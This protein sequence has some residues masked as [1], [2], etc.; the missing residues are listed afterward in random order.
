[1]GA[2]CWEHS[3]A[4]G[5]LGGERPGR[6]PG[7]PGAGVPRRP[8]APAAGANPGPRQSLLHQGLAAL[9]HGHPGGGHPHH[10]PAFIESHE[11]GLLGEQHAGGRQLQPGQNLLPELRQVLAGGASGVVAAIGATAWAGTAW[12]RLGPGEARSVAE[13]LPGPCPA[14]D[15]LALGPLPEPLA[16][17]L[18]P[19]WPSGQDRVDAPIVPPAT[20]MASP[21]SVR[22]GV[23]AAAPPARAWA[24][25][26]GAVAVRC[27]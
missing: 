4:A 17:R 2:G 16:G 11:L 14:G 9:H 25:R 12:H 23:P 10:R 13:G 20:R 15:G 19:G 1:M 18:P 24:G 26:C 22:P 7:R 3:E 6:G 27:P 8:P 21:P 5:Y